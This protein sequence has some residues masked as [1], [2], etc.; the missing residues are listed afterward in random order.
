MLVRCS[1]CSNTC[2]YCCCFDIQPAEPSQGLPTFSEEFLKEREINL[3]GDQGQAHTAT[4]NGKAL[5]AGNDASGSASDDM[6]ITA[7]VPQAAAA[8]GTTD[9]RLSLTGGNPGGAAHGMVLPFKPMAFS[10]RNICYSV[11]MP[12]EAAG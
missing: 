5:A 10:F 6:T 11:N 1:A 9:K 3:K 2:C 8:N 4:T 12:R 7:V